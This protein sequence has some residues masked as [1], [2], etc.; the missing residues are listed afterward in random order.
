MPA[1]QDGEISLFVY[2]NYDD[3]TPSNTLFSNQIVGV[4]PETPDTFFNTI[5]P[6]SPSQYA[7]ANEGTKFWQ[8]VYCATRANF[9]TLQYTFSNLQMSGL[10]QQKEVEI[11]AQI[12][13]IRKAG[14][15]TQL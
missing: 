11:D 12:L 9:I 6:T 7:V 3:L 13:W 2:L 15:L 1:V 14:R 5:I 8:R 10:P 4:T